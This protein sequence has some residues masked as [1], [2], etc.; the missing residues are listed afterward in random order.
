LP[1]LGLIYRRG[2]ERD[3]EAELRLGQH[4]DRRR[5][6]HGGWAWQRRPGRPARVDGDCGVDKGEGAETGEVGPANG[7]DGEHGC[8]GGACDAR[9]A[10]ARDASGAGALLQSARS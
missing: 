9:S 7:V 10:H 4:D 1:G 3:L 6:A 5:V 2:K 8:R